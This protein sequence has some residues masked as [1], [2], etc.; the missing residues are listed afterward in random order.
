[1][2][3][4]P[5][6]TL[7][8]G[9]DIALLSMLIVIAVAI[10]VTRS[11]LAAILL[12]SVYSLIVAT[13]FVVL[14]APDVAFTEAV[15]GAGVSTIVLLGATL[16]ARVE[17]EKRNWKT[18]VVPLMI[19][20]GTGAILV[21]A[22]TGLPDFGDAGS[23]ANQ[24]VG[25]GYLQTTPGDIGVPNVV[26]AVL[27]SY[28][29]FDTLGETVVIFAAGIGVV[30]MLGF[31]ERSLAGRDPVVSPRNGDRHVVLR[32]AAKLLIPLIALFAFYVQFHGDL[33]A[34]G[35]FQAGVILAVAIILHA[36]VFGL[37]DT[38]AAVR[39][40]FARGMAALG[41]LLYAGVG[42]V[43]VV[44]GGAFLDYDRLFTPE[45]EARIPDW[46]LP[47]DHAHH[48]GQHF[49]IFLV[50]LGVMLTVAA[51]MVTIFY[52]FAGRLSDDPREAGK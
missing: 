17:A 36:L 41:V 44:N 47:S 14:D 46:I 19:A 18:I 40:G 30:L 12:M 26:T 15:V 5:V 29:G 23:P 8:L 28:R 43:C 37:R 32:V 42:I 33:G 21:Y 3:G 7:S 24:H 1:M 4:L 13:W 48:W 38:M 25:R 35:G 31:G 39:P 27:A 9:I 22:A 51:T 52:G 49:G 45:I 50:E 20:A 10:S 34:G 16:L 11:L 2:I 6:S